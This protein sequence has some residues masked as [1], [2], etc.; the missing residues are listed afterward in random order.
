M[1]EAQVLAL[2]EQYF[3]TN[4][5][6]L[7]KPVADGIV[8]TLT[9]F[10]ETR[11]TPL[12]ESLTKPKDEA[13]KPGEDDPVTARL[14]ALEKQLEDERQA[15]QTEIQ[16]NLDLDF[17]Q[18]LG[19]LLGGKNVLHGEWLRK[20]LVND[21]RKDAK[22]EGDRWLT[23]DG[24]TLDEAV[25]GFL[26]TDTGKHFLPPQSTPGTGTPKPGKPVAPKGDAVTV[27]DIF[28]ALM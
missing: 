2:I 21:L 7:F 14:K 12:E 15:R 3:N 13:A 4:G 16:K 17:E 10:M 6:K 22:K 11:I 8:D 23:A 27:N 25:E 18:S 24:K 20:Q 28:A 19:G 26:S 5:E 1:D 9:G